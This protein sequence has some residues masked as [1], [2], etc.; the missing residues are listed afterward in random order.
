MEFPLIGIAILKLEIIVFYS[1]PNQSLF[2][3]VLYLTIQ[4]K[5]RGRMFTLAISISVLTPGRGF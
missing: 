1:V 3:F 2:S 5:I 4:K